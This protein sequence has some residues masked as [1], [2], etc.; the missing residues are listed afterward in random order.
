MARS[1]IDEFTFYPDEATR[2][3]LSAIPR[4]QRSALVNQAVQRLW[5][6]QVAAMSDE[7]SASAVTIDGDVD[8]FGGDNESV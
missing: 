1:G 5:D 3:I 8:I 6:D 2:E 4:G 7:C